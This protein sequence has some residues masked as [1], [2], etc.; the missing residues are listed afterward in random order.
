[1]R[2][3][4]SGYLAFALP[5]LDVVDVD[6]TAD[7]DVFAGLYEHVGGGNDIDDGGLGRILAHD[8]EC[9]GDVVR[10]VAECDWEESVET[11]EKL[12]AAVIVCCWG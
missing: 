3:A 11:E 2:E 1:M 10:G 8:P 9:D 5:L 7:I 4:M 12:G 6:S